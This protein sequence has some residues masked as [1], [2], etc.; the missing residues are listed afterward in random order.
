MISLKPFSSRTRLA[1][2][3]RRYMW[4][5]PVVAALGM[6]SGLLEGVGIGLLIP[7]LGTLLGTGDQAAQ[8]GLVGLLGRFAHG[9]SAQG[10]LL[11]VAGT[12]LGLILLKNLLQMGSHIL[13]AAV[14]GRASDAIRRA[15]AD[16]LLTAPY[17]FHLTHDPARLVNIVATES[18]HASDAIQADFARLES[19][20]IAVIFVVMLFF[21][22][23]QLTMV[24]VAG[25]V[26][27]RYL[28]SALLKPVTT[29]GAHV[30]TANSAL[31][32]RMLASI[33][34]TRVIRLFR[35]EAV[36]QRRFDEASDSVRR[37]MF[38]VSRRSAFVWPLLEVLRVALFLGVLL[39]AAYRGVSF[40]ELAT[41]LVL[42]NR[43]QPHLRTVE[44][45][46]TALASANAQ[47]AEVEW[48]LRAD[49]GPLGRDGVDAR[50][51]PGLSR[52]IAFQDVRFAYPTRMEAPSLH[53]VS[54]T[55]GAGRA[56]AVIGRSGSGKSTIINLLCRLVEPSSGTITVDGVPIGSFGVASWLSAIGVA[57]QDVDLVDGTVE[58]NI[59]YG[60][61]DLSWADVEAAARF[62]DAHDFVD[63]LP[64]GYATR[65]GDGGHGLSGGQRQRI[66]IARAIVGQPSIVI[67]DEATNSVDA[68]SEAAIFDLLHRLPNRP[69]LLVVSHRASTIA[70]CDDGIVVDD[71]RIVETGRLATMAAYQR[72]VAMG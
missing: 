24:V 11:A 13:V 56:T 2:I 66:G 12:M 30:T 50:P 27:L 55:I 43:L 25:V 64:D 34:Q 44:D 39:V 53:G 68:L 3:S 47:V 9:M 29:G 33:Y 38:V 35:R 10:R 57:G 21:V 4:T 49:G 40:P 61:A 70:L 7:L 18:W 65:V 19:A 26:L 17:A 59:R 31:F 5:L 45:M 48:L 20:A 71:G 32:E 23:G 62:A 6:V 42:L 41:M 72:L 16:R 46:T 67:L 54:F 1:D 69:T 63:A 52:E 8:G 51:F 60:R 22:Q 37:A 15:L 28:Q 36:E 58:D 14:N